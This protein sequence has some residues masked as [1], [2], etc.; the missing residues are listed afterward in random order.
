M[1]PL[2][3]NSVEEL[4]KYIPQAIECRVVRDEKTG[5][6]KIK[7]RTKRKLLTLIV[8]INEVDKT[9]EELS[10]PEVIEF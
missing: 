1:A 7:V 5:K 6:A 8:P 3:V 4:K 2:Q 10:C 9:L